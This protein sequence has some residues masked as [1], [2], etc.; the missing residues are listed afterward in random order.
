MKALILAAGYSLQLLL[1][2]ISSHPTHSTQMSPF[3]KKSIKC[4][5]FGKLKMKVKGLEAVGDIALRNL[6][7]TERFDEACRTTKGRILEK[8]STRAVL[9]ASVEV[10]EKLERRTIYRGRND[11]DIV[12]PRHDFKADKYYHMECETW[13]VQQLDVELPQLVLNGKTLKLNRTESR[14]VNVRLGACL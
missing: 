1:L 12:Y 4:S 8:L 11:R 6:S 13:K 2:E 9:D 14:L 3:K 5:L 10:A 7:A